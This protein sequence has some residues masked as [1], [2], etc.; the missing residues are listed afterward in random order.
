MAYSDLIRRGDAIAAMRAIK[1]DILANPP[2]WHPAQGAADCASAIA[3]LPAAPMG[4]KVKP[5][6]WSEESG[7]EGYK[8]IG[9]SNPIG[10][11][12]AYRIFILGEGFLT[13]HL[14]YGEGHVNLGKFT[15]MEDAQTAAQAVYE[16]CILA[17]I[18]PQPAPTLR[19]ALE[20][21]EIRALVDALKR[22]EAFYQM[23]LLDAPKGEY[24]KVATLRQSAL[25]ALQTEGGV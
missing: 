18:T 15:T 8:S 9:A 14:I 19:D 2:T 24:E 6:E 4:V 21:P 1:D 20:L 13:T 16:A 17:A 10:G 12:D 25:A 22:D 7:E 5:L 3:A 23:G 11:R